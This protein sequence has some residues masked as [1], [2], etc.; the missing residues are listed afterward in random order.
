MRG[1]KPIKVM[2]ILGTIIGIT[3]AIILV[4]G[5]IIGKSRNNQN[6]SL[7]HNMKLFDKNQQKTKHG[8]TRK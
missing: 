7:L 5:F 3:L 1:H 6:D 4:R 2:G 8:N